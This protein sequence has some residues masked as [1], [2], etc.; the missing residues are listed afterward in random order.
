[1]LKF[2]YELDACGLSCPM[3]LLKM[4]QRLNS[5]S[6]GERLKV[7]STDSG[8][9]KDFDAFSRQS[10]HSLVF[11]GAENAC[12]IFIIEKQSANVRT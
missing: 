8:S 12:F 10:G 11:S 2:D 1:M 7:L 6:S 9:V 4:K 5:M 3:P